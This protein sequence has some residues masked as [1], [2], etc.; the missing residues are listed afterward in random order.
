MLTQVCSVDLSKVRHTHI[1]RA[2]YP[3]VA[4]QALRLISFYFIC[5]DEV[6]VEF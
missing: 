4:G 3:V 2:A 6:G 5:L 1:T